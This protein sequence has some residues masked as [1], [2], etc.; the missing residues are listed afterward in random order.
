MTVAELIGLAIKVSMGLIVLALG[1]GANLD[2]AVCLVRRP[3][4]LVR[5]LFAMNIAM[6]A[7]AVVVAALFN[8]HPAI[9]IALGALALSPVPPILP[10]KQAK[11]GGTASY[12]VALLI[13]TAV[14]AVVVA[15]LGALVLGRIFGVAR[16]VPAGIVAQV[17]FASVI[18]PL[19]IGLAIHQVIPAFAGRIAKPISIFATVLLAVA[20]LPI[21]V[22]RWPTLISMVGNGTLLI[23]V[24]FTLIGI[25]IGHL[26]G[27]PNL[28]DRAVLALATGTRH[29]GVALAIAAAIFPAETDVLPVVLWHLIVGA[30]VSAP[31]VSWQKRRHAVHISTVRPSQGAG[32]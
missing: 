21:L 8:L 30:I 2:D 29:P 28:D 16:T 26:L 27:G 13:T 10:N 6:A 3:G 22:N 12:V 9:K 19:V 15:P 1:L 24:I 20:F 17:V 14:F 4:L 32:P 11:A 23:L 25:G 7:F 31:Y 18:A 5:S